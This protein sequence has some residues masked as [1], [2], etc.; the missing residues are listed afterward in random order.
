MKPTKHVR[1]DVRHEYSGATVALPTDRYVLQQ[2]F[3]IAPE[4]AD[5]LIP[6]D[7]GPD[8]K[9]GRWRDVKPDCDG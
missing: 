2:F 3:E 8:G 9:K 1:W 6:K 7:I 5:I 4:D